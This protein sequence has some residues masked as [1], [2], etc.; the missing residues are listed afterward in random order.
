MTKR[1]WEDLVMAGMELGRVEERATRQVDRCQWVWGELAEEVGDGSLKD[2]AEKVGKE[3]NTL[4]IYRIVVRAFPSAHRCADVSFKHHREVLTVKDPAKRQGWLQ[5]A[6]ENNKSVAA[7]MAAI[8]EQPP[9][10]KDET[11]TPTPPSLPGNGASPGRSIGDE[12]LSLYVQPATDRKLLAQASVE[13]WKAMD[14]VSRQ[15]MLGRRSDTATFNRQD[16]DSIEWALWSWNPVTGCLHNCSYCYARDIAERFYAWKFAPTFLPSRLDAPMH[17]KVPPGNNIGGKNVFTCS[18][19][20][21]FGKWVPAEW[22]EAVLDS[23][24]QNPQWNFL[25]LTKFPSRLP[26]FDFPDNAWIGTTIDAQARIPH[27]EECFAKTRAR[28]KW[29]S[30]EPM[31]E[32]LT[33]NRLDLFD[34]IVAGGASASTQ[35]PEFRPPREWIEHLEGQARK[36]GLK[37]YEKTNL[38]SRL[39]EYPGQIEPDAMNVHDAFDMGYIQRDVLAPQ[40]YKP[41]EIIDEGVAFLR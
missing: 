17:T 41:G 37:I 26:D 15:A 36:A 18:M 33:F 25:F 30:C 35:T 22:I 20:D 23:V 21:L 8:R 24:R 5:W 4:R 10:I 27:A 6:A 38:L 1:T 31:L 40:N 11:A 14:E 32:R 28:V 39:R 7:M 12:A 9:A 34:W 19:A 29:L 2:Y 16:N 3:Y 13:E